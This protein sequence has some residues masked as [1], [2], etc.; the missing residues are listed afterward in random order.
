VNQSA[1]NL[2]TRREFVATSLL[3]AAALS[4]GAKS[5]PR[6]LMLIRYDAESRQPEEMKGFFEKMVSVHRAEG[7]PASFFCLGAAVEM[8]EVEFQAFFDEVKNDPLFDIQ[9]HSYLH[10]GVGYDHGISVDELR[11]DFDRSFDVQERMRGIRPIGVSLAGTGSRDGER[12][13]GFDATEKSRAE[14]D[15]LAGLGVRMINTFH[16]GVDGS[17]NFINYRD[18]GHPEMMG[19]PSGNGDNGWLRGRNYGD[20]REYILSQIKERGARGEH[21]PLMFHDDTVF[22]DVD[23]KE[24]DIVRLVADAGR[25]AGFELVTHLES[26]RRKSLWADFDLAQV[27]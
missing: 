17:K 16:S 22:I 1:K 27:T 3:G 14:L 20:P 25:K 12:L 10:V 2:L 5:S 13:A 23:D 7:I 9:D 4:L 18:L 8:R 24:L 26:Y 21:M 15:M 11:A 6:P 19:F